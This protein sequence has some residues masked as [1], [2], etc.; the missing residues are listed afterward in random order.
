VLD[1]H[2]FVL[3]CG[4][5]VEPLGDAP[6]V[7]LGNWLIETVAYD[8]QRL[9]LELEMN[10]GDRYQHFGVPRR[11]AIGLVQANEPAR[12][13][14]EFIQSTYRFERVRVQR[15]GTRGAAF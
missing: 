4:H 10:K 3:D 2:R 11:V 1:C 12:Y 5:L 8:R 14:E 9:I 7:N 15:H 6:R 13:W